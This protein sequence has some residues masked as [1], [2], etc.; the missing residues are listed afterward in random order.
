M[1]EVYEVKIVSRIEPNSDGEW[2]TIRPIRVN[3]GAKYTEVM[4]ALDVA[5]IPEEFFVVQYK[6]RSATKKGLV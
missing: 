3:H 6:T 5:E 4:D 1:D 2:M